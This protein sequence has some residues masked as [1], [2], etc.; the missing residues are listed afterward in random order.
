MKPKCPNC[1]GK[2][3]KKVDISVTRDYCYLEGGFLFLYRC[4][5]CHTIIGEEF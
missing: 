5:K 1:K 4:E 3:F 2:N